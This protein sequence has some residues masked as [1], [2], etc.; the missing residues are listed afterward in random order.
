MHT[1]RFLGNE[2]VH[3]LSQATELEFNAALDIVEAILTSIYIL[4]KRKAFQGHKAQQRK[5]EKA[6]NKAN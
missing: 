3:Q 6:H 4:P 5:N 2:A 1:Q